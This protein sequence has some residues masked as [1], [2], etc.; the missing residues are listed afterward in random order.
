VAKKKK[1]R[2]GVAARIVQMLTR[3][4]QAA[5][6]ELV[7]YDI[8]FKLLAYGL[9]T[10]LAAGAVSL[11]IGLTGSTAVSNERIAWFLLTPLGW[12]TVAVSLTLTFFIAFLEESG[13]QVIAASR[14]RGAALSA[15]GAIRFS[16]RHGLRVIT[17]AALQ[18]ALMALVVVPL[19]A[20][21]AGVYFSLLRGHDINYY[22]ALRP[23]IF[24][25]AVA[26]G[27]ALAAV[28]VLALGYLHVRWLFALP[29]CILEGYKA[30]AAL[31]ESWRLTRGGL[32]RLAAIVVVWFL[33]TLLLGVLATLLMWLAKESA[34]AIAG[35]SLSLLVPAL[36]TLVVL[37]LVLTAA[38]SFIA[39]AA[40]ALIVVRLY[41]QAR[42]GALKSFGSALPAAATALAGL[43]AWA[44]KRRIV[45]TA[46]IAFFLA[47]SLFGYWIVEQASV[48]RHVDITA[49]R[50]SKLRAPENTLAAIQLAIDEQAD[51]VEIDVQETA[52][53]E[54][55]LLH[56]K[57][58]MR[59]AGV[60]RSIWDI[61]YDELGDIDVGSRFD[62]RFAS[63]RIPTLAQAIAL[64]R[65]KAKLNIELK[66]NGHDQ[67]L[68][69]RVVDIVRREKF[70]RDCVISSLD[71]AGLAE[72]ERLAPELTTG[73]IVG[74][75][76][77]NVGRIENDFL[78]A[79]T[80][81]VRQDLVDELH[82]RGRKLHAWT[83]ADEPTATRLMEM[84]VDNLIT[85]DP[86][87][88]VEVRRR[89]EELSTVERLTLAVRRWL[90]G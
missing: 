17:L 60:R 70:E 86:V 35:E 75:S 80:R 66:F 24:L 83:V 55:I 67:K 10:P 38:T 51:Y 87:L 4:A 74:A 16:L 46:M 27:F 37:N 58:L 90:A 25:T 42:A 57:D 56:D 22:L 81:M 26:I 32:L 78:S 13:M 36:G 28:G 63:E 79:S 88:M 73:L 39:I 7:V 52:D 11:L 62:P 69:E 64:A 29:L 59:V 3:D 50:G 65:G 30:R 2:T 54:I 40:H 72:V 48:E 43:P 18:V 89:R 76:I 34:L 44:T 8:L 41:E 53:G 21:A 14:N 15:I 49:H 19:V 47:M 85:D 12:A 1:K 71:A 5:W 31:V 23:P 9:L 82:R 33:A 20:I 77:G 61:R 6:R 84:G 68:A 45:F